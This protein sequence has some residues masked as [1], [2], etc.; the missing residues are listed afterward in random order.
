MHLSVGKAS[1]GL[2]ANGSKRFR[3]GLC[4]MLSFIEV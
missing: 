3:N 1:E 2:V 4:G